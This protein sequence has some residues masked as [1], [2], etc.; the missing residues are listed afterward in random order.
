M[1]VFNMLYPFNPSTLK[2]REQFYNGFSLNKALSFFST[3]PQFFAVDPGT[4]TKIIKNKKDLNKLFII[5][6]EKNLRQKLIHF[7]PE[8]VYYDRNRYKDPIKCL[9]CMDFKKCFDCD[10]FLWKYIY[11]N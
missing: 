8:D 7:L 9:K 3:I 2:Q 10:N 4:E 1:L 5:Y 11:K 6:S